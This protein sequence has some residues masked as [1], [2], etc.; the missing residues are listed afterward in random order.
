M[1]QV[2]IDLLPGFDA[3]TR[4]VADAGMPE[5]ATMRAV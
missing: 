5:D 4:A 2:P 3:A 1:A